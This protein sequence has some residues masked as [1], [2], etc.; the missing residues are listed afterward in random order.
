[1]KIIISLVMDLYSKNCWSSKI[2]RISLGRRMLYF[3][4]LCLFMFFLC[5]IHTI[6]ILNPT[7][8]TQQVL[9]F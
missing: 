5:W 2:I 1:M 7:L 6:M 4:Y 9:A 8:S 3:D